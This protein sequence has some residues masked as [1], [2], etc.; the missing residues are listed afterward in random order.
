[1]PIDSS[2]MRFL[3]LNVLFSKLIQNSIYKTIRVQTKLHHERGVLS[4]PTDQ[5]HPNHL[6][7]P[8]DFRCL[9]ANGSKNFKIK[10]TF[11]LF[12]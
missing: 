11:S 4:R 8:Y 10:I 9:T 5:G 7:N 2:N 12:C 3:S 6:G 1:M